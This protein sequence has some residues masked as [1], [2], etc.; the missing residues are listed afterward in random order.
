[1][2][3]H[4]TD[5]YKNYAVKYYLNKEN[6]DGY[7]KTCKIFDWDIGFTN[8]KLLQKGNQFFSNSNA[9]KYYVRIIEERTTY[10]ARI[11]WVYETFNQ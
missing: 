6:G 9:S 3:K 2:T 11:G 8:I 1:M 5:Y 7:K 4:K 10:N